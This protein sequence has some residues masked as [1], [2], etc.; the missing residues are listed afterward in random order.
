M[1]L[2]SFSYNLSGIIPYENYIYEIENINANW[3]VKILPLSGIINS[4]TNNATIDSKII[5]CENLNSCSGYMSYSN[6]LYQLG[7]DPFI[8]LRVKLTADSLDYPIYS[9]LT[10]IVCSGCFVVP[11]ININPNTISLE[12]NNSTELAITFN[13][14]KPYTE[15]FYVFNDVNSNY[16]VSLTNI[17]KSGSF[18]SDSTDSYDLRANLVFCYYE[19][20]S[21]P[22]FGSGNIQKIEQQQCEK[23]YSNFNLSLTSNYLIS[24]IVSDTTTLECDN[25]LPKTTISTPTLVILNDASNK[26]SLTGT[27]DGLKPYNRYEYSILFKEANHRVSFSN[28]SGYFYTKNETNKNI[29]TTL[30]FCESSGLCEYDNN[31]GDIIDYD[32]VKKKF[33]EFSIQLDSD[34][35][36]N[37][38]M[39][40]MV[41]V[42]CD[43]CLP[44]VSVSLPTSINTLTSTNLISITGLVSGLK[45][46]QSYSYYFTGDNN[47][48]IVLDNISG[49]FT[50]KTTSSSIVTKL[51]FCSPSGSCSNENGLLSYQPSTPAQKAINNNFLYGKLKLNVKS[52]NCSDI[53]YSSNTYN[54]NCDDCL[55]CLTY[56]NAVISGS[57][58]II[59]DDGCCV[60]QQLLTVNITNAIPGDQYIYEF[61]T[62]SGVGINSIVFNP[63]SGEMYFGSGGAGT[64]NTI[65]SVDLADYSQTLINF[66]LTNTNTNFK[67]FDTVGLVC[68]TGSCY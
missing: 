62:S 27:F 30:A 18:I 49:S 68:N 29:E 25:C 38:I 44:M 53:E 23:Y 52:L 17:P 2:Q 37:S 11:S 39:G 21:S 4:P 41:R 42:D 10:S 20:C 55:P 16:P 60:G 67:V 15:Y 13:N 22:T 1:L 51:L 59:L 28:I 58:T 32:C 35:L 14:L 7:E 6:D 57:P 40:D 24:S 45:P 19:D 48:P 33:I 61:S 50:P 12:D 65:C 31:L 66:E 56:A 43:N 63:V 64:I 34:C 36:D 3:P 9:D 46:F 26:Y 47:W 5:F 8:D 54:I